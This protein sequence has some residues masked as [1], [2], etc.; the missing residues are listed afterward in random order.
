ML[1]ITRPMTCMGVRKI[2]KLCV[3]DGSNKK[4][5]PKN[6]SSALKILFLKKKN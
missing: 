4:I 2:K 5:S 3:V 1:F 6:T